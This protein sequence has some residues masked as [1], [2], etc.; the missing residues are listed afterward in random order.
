MNNGLSRSLQDTRV[1]KYTDCIYFVFVNTF[2]GIYLG[3]PRSLTN[4]QEE[5]WPCIT[6][7]RQAAVQSISQR[8]IRTGSI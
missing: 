1:M 7:A 4:R 2:I 3:F 5:L 6:D 8:L